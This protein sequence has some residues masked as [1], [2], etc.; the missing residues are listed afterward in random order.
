MI[1]KNFATK[2]KIFYNLFCKINYKEYNKNVINQDLNIEKIKNKKYVDTIKTNYYTKR[3]TY[4]GLYL[5][6][7]PYRVFRSQCNIYNH[8][9]IMSNGKSLELSQIKI[10]YVISYFNLDNITY[11]SNN[12]EPLIDI[13]MAS[14]FLNRFCL[15]KKIFSLKTYQFSNAYVIFGPAPYNPF[16]YL[17]EQAAPLIKHISKIPEG[18]TLILPDWWHIRDIF[19]LLDLNY[20]LKFVKP[21]SLIELKNCTV[22]SSLPERIYLDQELKFI[23]DTI[24]KKMTSL[25]THKI[26]FCSRFDYER[27]R[28]KLINEDEIFDLLKKKFNDICYFQPGKNS[29]EVQFQHFFNAEIFIGQFGA[30]L[31][32]NILWAKNLKLIIEFVPYDHFGE[33]E[34]EA[35]AEMRGSKYYKVKTY[36]T[37]PGFMIYHNQTCDIEELSNILKSI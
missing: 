31:I 13:S 37:E 33:T 34:T 36:S 19:K 11:Y 21:N 2:I 6:S 3:H 12:S 25:L 32:A 8:S 7:H 30:N 29:V 14:N 4:S 17:T 24:S 10:P 18:S 9:M 26:I 27:D 23:R 28:R 15:L 35:I 20:N 1:S 22:L 16:H 5:Y